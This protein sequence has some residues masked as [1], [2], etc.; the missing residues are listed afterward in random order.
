MA[1]TE[2]VQ[3]TQLNQDPVSGDVAAF[4]V[5]LYSWYKPADAY[6]IFVRADYYDPNRFVSNAGYREIFFSFGLDYIPAKE[7]HF[8]PNL[9][10]NS[11]LD[12]SSL[13]RHKDADIVPRITFLF[14]FGEAHE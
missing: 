2:I 4:G 5:S 3:Q 1:G 8:M 13:N 9:W 6:K 11:F 14:I 10:V 12:K 7:I